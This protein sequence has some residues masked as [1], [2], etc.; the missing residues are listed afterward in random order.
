MST[1][2]GILSEVQNKSKNLDRTSDCGIINSTSGSS[3]TLRDN[4]DIAM[5]ASTYTQY[6]L[7][8]D[9]GMATEVSLQSNTLTNR[10]NLFAD[11]ITINKHKL[12]PKLYELSDMRVSNI[13]A[14]SAIGNL[15]MSGTVLVRAW[16]PTLKKYVLMRR[17]IRMPIFSQLLN[18]ADA[19][20]NLN[21]DTDISGDLAAL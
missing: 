8:R 12:N 6:K 18:L 10:K 4:G 2:T 15:T 17:Q 9:N 13:S 11:E 14:D 3:V 21:L 16:E 5:S 1:D 20:E 19:P 7:Q